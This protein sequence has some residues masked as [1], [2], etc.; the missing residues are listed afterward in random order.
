MLIDTGESDYARGKI[1]KAMIEKF[2]DYVFLIE[3]GKVGSFYITDVVFDEDTDEI[4]GTLT[5]GFA[6]KGLGKRRT[7][8]LDDVDVILL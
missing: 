5:E 1:V 8:N 2:S 7:I 4:S 6:G 3:T